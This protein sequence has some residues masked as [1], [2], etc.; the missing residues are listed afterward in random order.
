MKNEKWS[1]PIVDEIHRI[2]AEMAREAGYDLKVMVEKLRETEKKFAHKLVSP[3]PKPKKVYDPKNRDPSTGKRVFAR[4]D[5]VIAG[6][7][8]ARDMLIAHFDYDVDALC[9]WIRE[10]AARQENESAFRTQQARED[11]EGYRDESEF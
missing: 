3:P 11:A 10:A 1:D 6:V 9:E 7:S 8:R 4:D 5:E 2:R